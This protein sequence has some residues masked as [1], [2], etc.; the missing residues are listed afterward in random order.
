MK[1]YFTTG[2]QRLDIL[3][4]HQFLNDLPNAFRAKNYIHLRI[5]NQ[6][7]RAEYRLLRNPLAAALNTSRNIKHFQS[8]TSLSVLKEK[9]KVQS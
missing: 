7:S 8:Y 9:L 3:L 5:L 6:N 2:D 4:C 1:I